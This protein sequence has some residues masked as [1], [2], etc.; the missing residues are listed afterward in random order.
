M[1][2]FCGRF[3]QV[4]GQSSTGAWPRS[5]ASGA[6]AFDGLGVV[7]GEFGRDRKGARFHVIQAAPA[8]DPWGGLFLALDVER[9]ARSGEVI[10]SSSSNRNLAA[11]PSAQAGAPWQGKTAVET[12]CSVVGGQPS[13]FRSAICSLDSEATG[14]VQ[15]Q[16]VHSGEWTWRASFD[17]KNQERATSRCVRRQVAKSS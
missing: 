16:L 2:A 9:E 6:R 8:F 7:A 1:P 14:E 10:V 13:R 5:A 17:I 11:G 3:G 12:L 15:E 4:A